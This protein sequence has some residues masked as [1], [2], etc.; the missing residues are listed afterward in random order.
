MVSDC[1]K[2]REYQVA[3]NRRK[4]DL[5]KMLEKNSIDRMHEDL[6]LKDKEEKRK[7]EEREVKK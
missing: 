3:I 4:D 1:L 5:L 2:E 6:R 7:A